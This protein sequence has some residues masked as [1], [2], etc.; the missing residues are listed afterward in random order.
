MAKLKV[1]VVFRNQV[2]RYSVVFGMHKTSV[3]T[4]RMIVDASNIIVHNRYNS[5]TMA[6]DI[7]IIGKSLLI[8]CLFCFGHGNWFHASAILINNSTCQLSYNIDGRIITAEF[9]FQLT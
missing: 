1:S 5:R 7:A 9:S 8:A 2:R 6:N 3:T 4:G